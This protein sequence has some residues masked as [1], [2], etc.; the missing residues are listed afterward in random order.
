MDLLKHHIR[1]VDPETGKVTNRIDYLTADEE[2]NYVIAQANTRLDD[3]GHL[4][5]K[6]L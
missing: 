2:D 6:K 4:L 1:R 5:M 3:D